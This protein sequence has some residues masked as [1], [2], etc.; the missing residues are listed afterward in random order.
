MLKENSQIIKIDAKNVFLDVREAFV[1]DRVVLQFRR[2]DQSLSK[3]N[4][5]TQSIDYYLSLEDFA[6]LCYVFYSG[7]INKILQKQ[8]YVNYSGS[9]KNGKVI[10]RIL[11]IEGG[12]DDK[13]FVKAQSGPGKKT[14]TGA[15]SPVFGDKPDTEIV[16]KLSSEQ[17]KKFG[18]AGERALRIR[19]M[20]VA[21]GV[22]D[23]KCEALR[24]KKIEFEEPI[25]KI[26]APVYEGYAA[27]DL[28]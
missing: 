9:V 12:Q 27:L 21:M 20:W 5:I 10:S 1:I 3:G 26:P 11:K 19:D 15:I 14:A 2:Y 13:F 16:I 6:Y 7:G 24:F 23:E 17:I 4:K 28:F 22:L 25:R 18:L 8:S